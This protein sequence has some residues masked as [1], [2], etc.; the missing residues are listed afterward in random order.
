[1]DESTAAWICFHSR[2]SG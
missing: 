1:M 2:C